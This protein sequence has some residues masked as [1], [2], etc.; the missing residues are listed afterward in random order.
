MDISN[1]L[2]NHWLAGF[3]DS[4]GSF[5]VKV[6]K[7]TNRTETRLYLQVDQKTNPLLVLIKNEFGGYIGHR[8]SQDTYYY[9]STSF[10]AAKKVINYLD[11]YNMLSSKYLNY[12]KWRKVYEL[13]QERKH[14]TLEGQAIILKIKLSMNSYSKETFDLNI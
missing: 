1:N 5:Q 14:C 8:K 7:R 13:V 2:N 4:D 6:L 10:G 3:L 12:L 11:K 9:S